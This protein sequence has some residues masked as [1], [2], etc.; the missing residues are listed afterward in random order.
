[1]IPKIIHYCWLSGDPIPENLQKC[2]NSWKKHLPDYE[3]ILWDRNRFDI[4]STLWTK[5]AFEAK[6]Y[7]FAADYIRLYA[8]YNYG[9]IYMDMDVEVVKSFNE[10]L[11]YPYIF[12]FETANGIEAGVFGAEQHAPFLKD[13]LNY[14]DNRPFIQ[15][16]GLFDTRTLPTIIY[17]I[18]SH[19]KL[20]K[21][22][23]QLDICNDSDCFF[24]FNP[25][26]LTAK[27][28]KTGNIHI[29]KNTYTIHHFAGSWIPKRDKI[30]RDLINNIYKFISSNPILFKIYK[31]TYKKIKDK[32]NL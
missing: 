4:N 18:F 12:G 32:L 28:H 24:V 23:K 2:M 13:C 8:V 26:F 14:Y 22:R 19:N 30:K 10:L 27:S 6:K 16:D 15:K 1:M 31:N 9:G 7:A 11:N 5:Q 25:D 20:I 17:D 21:E 29:T 3:F